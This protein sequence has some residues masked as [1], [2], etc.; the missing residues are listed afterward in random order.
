V[1]G[2]NPS[3]RR[4]ERAIRRGEED[5]PATALE[6]LELVLEHDCLKIQLIE[7]TADEQ[8][9]QPAQKPVSDGLEHLGSQMPGWPACQRPGR[10]GRSSFFTHKLV[11][12]GFALADEADEGFD[13]YSH[14]HLLVQT[15]E[16]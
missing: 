10:S 15:E 5:S 6:D 16:G 7:A 2:Q 13:G 11:D 8:V 1:P 9:E 3:R 12:A 4:K 14:H